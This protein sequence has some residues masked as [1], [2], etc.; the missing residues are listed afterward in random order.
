MSSSNVEAQ[1]T[2]DLILTR[3]NPDEVFREFARKGL[4][5]VTIILKKIDQ[6]ELS[7]KKKTSDVMASR[8]VSVKMLKF[9]LRIAK[10]INFVTPIWM[11]FDDTLPPL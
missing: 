5:P 4:K 8:K 3:A 10:L 2:P 1:K 7:Q 9:N 6:D 11:I